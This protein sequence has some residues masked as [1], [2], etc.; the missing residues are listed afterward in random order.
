MKEIAF[1]LLTM[2]AIATFII[3]LSIGISNLF[4]F[5][6]SYRDKIRRKRFPEYFEML[7][8]LHELD[9][10]YNK[11]YYK[12]ISPRRTEIDRI[13]SN[14]NYYPNELIE[15]VNEEL[16]ELRMNLHNAIGVG[17]KMSEEIDNLRFHIKNYEAE[18][19]I[20]WGLT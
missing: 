10:E 14:M 7:D 8:K 12:E 19:N 17:R 5:I 13:I 2:V 18:N 4:S 15:K 16:E 20:T 1:V 11:F 6:F 3:L 9:K